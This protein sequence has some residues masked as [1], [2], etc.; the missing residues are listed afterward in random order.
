M[1][2]PLE[3]STVESTLLTPSSEQEESS[4]DLSTMLPYQEPDLG[5]LSIPVTYTNDPYTVR[6]WCK[7]NIKIHEC[8]ENYRGEGGAII[9]FDVEVCTCS[10]VCR[11]S[12]MYGNANNS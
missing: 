8:N 7:K 1:L 11:M 4:S 3:P 5:R 10:Q 2:P 6:R 12:M 9:G